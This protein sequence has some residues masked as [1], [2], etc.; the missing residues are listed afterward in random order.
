MKPLLLIVSTD[1]LPSG[2][3][4]VVLERPRLEAMGRPFGVCYEKGP[5]LLGPFFFRL[6]RRSNRSPSEF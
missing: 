4:Q 6:R 1:Q 2:N 3:L 5:L